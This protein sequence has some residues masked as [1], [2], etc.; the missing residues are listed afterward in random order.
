MSD[1]ELSYSSVILKWPLAVFE[2]KRWL[3]LYSGQTN[4]CKTFG[5]FLTI[6]LIIFVPCVRHALLEHFV[7]GF[8]LCYILLCIPP[9]YLLLPTYPCMRLALTL[10]GTV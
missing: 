9:P 10:K 8:Q 6:S 5:I 7:S 2:N 1:T 4:F 3:N